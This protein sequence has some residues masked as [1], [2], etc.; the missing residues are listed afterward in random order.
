MD[1]F[2]LDRWRASGIGP[3]CWIWNQQLR[4]EYGR[5]M[6]SK[7]TLA[8]PRARWLSWMYTG[9]WCPKC[10]YVRM[11]GL[12]QW[13]GHVKNSR[14]KRVKKPNQESRMQVIE[15][16]RQ[17]SHKLLFLL[18]YFSH[19]KFSPNETAGEANCL[20][21]IFFKLKVFKSVASV[22]TQ[23]TCTRG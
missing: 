1:L 21:Y 8:R 19:G 11:S 2:W 5:P 23:R 4:A 20:S 15:L 16:W 22:R 18:F 12:R 7:Y 13:H 10:S 6:I 9:Q 3:Q 14:W 17:I